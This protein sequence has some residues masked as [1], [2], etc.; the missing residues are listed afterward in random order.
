TATVHLTPEQ[1]QAVRDILMRQAEVMSAG[2]KQAFSG[3]FNKDEILKLGKDVGN[4]DEKIKALLTPDQQADYQTYQQ[5]EASHNASMAANS[6]LL[7][8]QSTLGLTP[9]QMDKVFAGL[10]D[11]NLNQLTGKA[12]QNA[13]SPVELMQWESEQKIKAL[14]SVLTPAQ[15]EKYRQQQAIQGKIT[16]DIWK[17]FEGSGSSGSPGGPGGSE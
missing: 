13:A 16:Q 11:L 10:Y 5:Q 9:G 14:E 7:Q 3:K 1:T 8:M 2:M 4:V 12:N 6:E 15:L 17:K